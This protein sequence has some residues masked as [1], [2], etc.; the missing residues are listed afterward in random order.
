MKKFIVTA[1]AFAPVL[2]FAQTL[3]STTNLFRSF[4]NLVNIALPIVVGLALLGFFWGLARFIFSAGDEEARKGAKDLMIYS[5][6]ALFIMV[7][8]WGII[9]FLATDLGVTNNNVPT[10]QIPNV[11][12]LNTR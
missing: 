3:N 10:I 6:I 1:L 2:T 9:N 12:N 7:S 4:G 8:I 5:V 11:G